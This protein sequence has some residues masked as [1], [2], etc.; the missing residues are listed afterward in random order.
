MKI[1]IILPTRNRPDNIKKWYDSYKENTSGIS[2]VVIMA[3]IDDDNDYSY[4]GF[5]IERN[6]RLNCI[7]KLN[8]AAE[9]YAQNYEIIGFLG[10][11][12]IIKT[13]DFDEKIYSKMS[14]DII[15]MLFPNDN[16]PKGSED[17][18]VKPTH[19][20][21]TKELYNIIG[22]FAYPKMHHSFVDFAWHTIG[23][24]LKT[25]IYAEDII[26]EH[27][28]P[29][30]YSDIKSD[31]VY[32]YAYEEKKTLNDKETYINKWPKELKNII[33]RIREK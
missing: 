12:T 16:L 8:L 10:D 32:N 22:Y 14:I 3:D 9:K 23:N 2:D 5:I 24:N 28:H 1:L 11:D 6:E 15:S 26:I 27:R 17:C 29:Y 13:K 18:W 30:Y 33:S 4:T 31:D 7:Q 25:Y 21:M 20:F 19:I